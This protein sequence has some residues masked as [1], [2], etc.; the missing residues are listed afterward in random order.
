MSYFSEKRVVVTGGAG[1]LGSVL[2]ALLRERGGRQIFIP[3]SREYDLTDG[4]EG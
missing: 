2:V 1:F 3:R 4:D